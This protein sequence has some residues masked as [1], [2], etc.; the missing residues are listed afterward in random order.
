MVL[1]LDGSSE[2]S[3]TI[4]NT[5]GIS[6]CERQLITSSRVVKSDLK[7]FTSYVGFMIW[8]TI[9]FR[10]HEKYV[11]ASA[12]NYLFMENI[13]YNKILQI[14]HQ[15][16]SNIFHACKFFSDFFTCLSSFLSV[17]LCSLSFIRSYGQ[18]VLVLFILTQLVFCSWHIKQT[19]VWYALYVHGWKICLNKYFVS[20]QRS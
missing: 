19:K 7:N 6:I 10:Y 8:A 20:P 16:C 5:S 15:N 1:I 11:F 4:W 18:F 13:C 12:P 3:A 17:C 9:L 2:H 14:W